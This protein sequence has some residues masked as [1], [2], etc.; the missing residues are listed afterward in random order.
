M[1]ASIHGEDVS[2]YQPNWSPVNDDFVFIKASEGTGYRNP[3]RFGQA[4]RARAAGLVVGWYHYMR[5]GNPLGQAAYFVATSGI[6]PGDLVACDWEYMV[7]GRPAVTCA[8]KDE[9]LREVN[10]L[11][12]K[13]KEGLYCNTWWWRAVDTTSY[14]G[15]FLW[16]AGPYRAASAGI[17]HPYLFWQYDDR[18]IDQNWGYF[19]T[20]AALKAWALDTQAAPPVD[21]KPPVVAPPPRHRKPKRRRAPK[22]HILVGAGRKRGH[23]YKSPKTV[24]VKWINNRRRHGGFSRHIWFLQHWLN[25]AG[26]HYGAAT[27]Y[28]DAHTQH[29][30]NK[31][32]TDHKITPEKGHIT[33]PVLNAL[34][35]EAHAGKKASN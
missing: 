16:I 26:Y 12:P 20:R 11:R 25:L 31:F 7:N 5:P 15:R 33:L 6:Q 34:R 10:R 17:Q 30:L 9:F 21:S 1:V 8:E 22:R 18:P 29:L 35:A 14:C 27:G 19:P 28:W 13:N 23:I 4:S 24:S 2:S 3:S 32:R